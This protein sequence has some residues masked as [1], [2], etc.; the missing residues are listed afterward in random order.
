MKQRLDP[1][2]G[3]TGHG[4]SVTREIKL[5]HAT[6]EPWH[7][8]YTSLEPLKLQGYKEAA[9]CS[10]NPP[11][12][13]FTIKMI[14]MCLPGATDVNR[15]STGQSQDMCGFNR[16]NPMVGILSCR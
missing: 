10:H 9:T 6:R 2:D 14:T 16:K 15:T 11:T 7:A 4:M 8:P 1:S 13:S 12:R 5:F 3:G